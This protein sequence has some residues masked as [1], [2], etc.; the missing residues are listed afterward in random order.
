MNKIFAHPN[1]LLKRLQSFDFLRGLDDP[2]LARLAESA[3]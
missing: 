1:P 2:T 3:T